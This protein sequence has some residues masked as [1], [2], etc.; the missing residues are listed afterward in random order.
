MISTEEIVASLRAKLPEDELR[1]TLNQVM[2]EAGEGIDAGLDFDSFL[3]VLRVSFGGEGARL[4]PEL[5]CVVASGAWEQ[6]FG[7]N[8]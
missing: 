5:E 7:C 3:K 6:G 4:G 2:A 1:A 8:G